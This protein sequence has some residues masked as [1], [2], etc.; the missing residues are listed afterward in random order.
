LDNAYLLK[1]GL[2]SSPSSPIKDNKQS[3]SVISFGTFDERIADGT[4]Q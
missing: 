4:G 2:I 3:I 1:P